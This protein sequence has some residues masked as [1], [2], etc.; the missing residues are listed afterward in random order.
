MRKQIIFGTVHMKTFVY[1]FLSIVLILSILTVSCL[2]T[3]HAEEDDK[4]QK[5]DDTITYVSGAN[6]ASESYISGKYYRHLNSLPLTG[7]DITNL[8]AVAL[9]QLGYMESDNADDFSGTIGGS[10]N[11]TEFNW[12]MGDFGV[13]Y[14]TSNY[15]W[16]ASFV[17]YCLLQS[18]C[19]DQRSMAD[20][21]RKHVA[22]PRYIWREV[23]CA[24][25]ADNIESAGYYKKSVAKGGDYVPQ[26]GD[27]I[28]FRWSPER[29]IGH[30]GIVVYSD[31]E[32]VYTVEGNT[33]GGSTMVPNGGGVY[34]KNYALD[35]SCIDGYGA[36]PYAKNDSSESIDYSG[37]AASTGLYI[38]TAEKYLYS[39]P[40][41]E[42]EYMTIPLYTIFEVTEVV[43]P[44]LGGM[45]KAKLEIDGEQVEGYVINDAE[46][47]VLQL[48]R[49][50]PK[51]API[52]F[53]PFSE[54]DGFIGGQVNDLKANGAVESSD[55]VVFEET[56][57]M[58]MTGVFG[59]NSKI[60]AFGYYVDNDRDNITWVEGGFYEAD[61]SV[62]KTCG[63]YAVECS[64][65]AELDSLSYAHHRVTFVLKL[66]NGA[67]PIVC[68]QYF[69][70]IRAPK[71]TK[72]PRPKPTETQSATE[73]DEM[74]EVESR[75]GTETEFVTENKGCGA[76]VSAGVFCVLMS[77]I[78]SC[79]Y[80]NRKREE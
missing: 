9:S 34:F 69:E 79:V 71:E 17:S 7:D 15:D 57:S 63:K 3:V 49:S 6:A 37:V 54:T 53:M 24:R 62:K 11:Y 31:G 46:N 4:S 42:S 22:D 12:N 41:V 1:R 75:L 2:T 32:R 61:D 27:L 64:V 30:I 10:S 74:S 68:S 59:F 73:A 80:F 23:G 28:F 48:S 52:S 13:G 60:V 72:P 20:W 44:G 70:V 66:D 58:T 77:L 29:Q 38:N 18:R 55:E 67:V 8:L 43:E 33:S 39:E 45:L 21:C 36:M 65:N 40:S 25:W 47:R 76:V 50:A 78:F 14:G 5:N 26:T 51:I 16:C 56:V 19:T 35:Y